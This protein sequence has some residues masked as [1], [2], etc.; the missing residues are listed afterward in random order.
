MIAA[1][2]EATSAARRERERALHLREAMEE[3]RRESQRLKPTFD[4]SGL[5]IGA[6]LARAAP[7]MLQ[8]VHRPLLLAP[9]FVGMLSTPEEAVRLHEA[10]VWLRSMLFEAQ[11]EARILVDHTLPDTERAQKE[12]AVRAQALYAEWSHR[13]LRE[14]ELHGDDPLHAN[15]EVLVEVKSWGADAREALIEAAAL[16]PY[17]LHV[18]QEHEHARLSS[19]ALLMAIHDLE[20]ALSEDEK[21]PTGPA[22]P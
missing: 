13:F 5:E 20:H 11:D 18:P 6:Y 9:V 7:S 22:H 1:S 16:A 8:A 2:D 10:S 19:L 12:H 14:R 17:L 3:M 15:R 4:A 21:L